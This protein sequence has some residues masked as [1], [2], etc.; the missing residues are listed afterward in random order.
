MDGVS[1]RN[2]YK[3]KYCKDVTLHN[4]AY[5][6]DLSIVASSI[7]ANQSSLDLTDSFMAW[8]RTMAAKPRKCK[9]LAFKYWCAGDD[10]AGR[11]RLLDRRYAPFDPELTIAGKPVGFI[12]HDYFKFLG[13][14]VYHHLREDDQKAQVMSDFEN[15]MN[16]VDASPVHGFMKLWLYQHYV[17]A[18]LAWP[19]MVYDL[20]VSWV[21]K[22]Q[23]IANR[24][25]KVWAG[26]YKRAVTSALYRCRTD[27]GLGLCSLVDFYKRLKVNQVSL[28][29]FSPDPALNSIYAAM[30]TR[31][32]TFSD[33]W[34]PSPVLERLD[35]QVDHKL[36]FNGQTDRLGLGY[37]RGRY[38]TSLTTAQRKVWIMDF[39]STELM[40]AYKI[41]DMNKAMQGCFLRFGDALPFDLSWRHLIGT[42]NPRLIRWVLNATINSVVTPDL[43]KLWGLCHSAKCPLCDHKQASLFHI[44]SGCRVA[45]AQR[46]YT[47][48]HDS[49]LITLQDPL[50][51]HIDVHNK[52]PPSVAARKILF[53]SSARKV[54]KKRSKVKLSPVS[55]L[56]TA[57]DWK[58]QID[59]TTSPTPFPAHICATDQRPDIVL[60]SDSTRTVIL[61]ELTCPAEENIADARFRKTIKYTE[62]KDQ[63]VDCGWSCHLKTIE[64]GVRGL[65]SASVPRAL[66]SLG[67]SNAATRD[68]SRKV[69]L[70]C[71]R[72]SLAIYQCHRTKHWTWRSLVKI[73]PVSPHGDELQRPV[74]R[75][76]RGEAKLLE[77]HNA[78]PQAVEAPVSVS[79]RVTWLDFSGGALLDIRTYEL[80]Q[81]EIQLK[82]DCVRQVL[83]L[84]K[85][86]ILADRL[87]KELF[88]DSRT[89]T[90]ED[91]LAYS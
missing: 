60:Y 62:L 88:M 28:L 39:L 44:L 74:T 18:Y 70:A 47:W 7:R 4:L 30:L 40:A 46:R 53:V 69:S 41:Q 79:K 38:A 56:G 89:L 23:V 3:L 34:R 27:L 52:A 63:I 5:A 33:W 22:L 71:A 87:E 76:Q 90:Q 37:M 11:K 13:W 91:L 17:V 75:N 57:P 78:T 21:T 43:R 59:F 1:E 85:Q 65:V 64:V 8:T 45:L 61:I 35:S 66:R 58:L 49:V 55:L 36:R 72:C 84:R 6:D 50:T 10:K 51:A 25:L 20:S 77:K 14:K 42:R 67:F 26:L 24:Y 82:R 2:G 83:E 68:L 86:N 48:R 32:Q 19:F 31:H 12:A 16:L 81:L 73:G 9:S 15:N 54:D 29:K 80:T